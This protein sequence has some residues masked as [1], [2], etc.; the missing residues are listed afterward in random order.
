M[1]S[2]IIMYIN[3]PPHT[4]F[5][6]TLFPDL[7]PRRK[8]SFCLYIKPPSSMAWRIPIYLWSS[9][10]IL[11]TFCPFFRSPTPGLVKC[12]WKV[13]YS[14]PS[15]WIL[16]NHT[17]PPLPFILLVLTFLGSTGKPLLLFSPR[18]TPPSPPG[19]LLVDPGQ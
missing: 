14:I 19:P 4:L 15:C 11:F 18:L 10:T 9:K 8:C 1:G 6:P 13:G 2:Q 16:A 3:P 7:R 5:F 12:L 17:F